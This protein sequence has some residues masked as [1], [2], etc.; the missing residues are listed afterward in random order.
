MDELTWLKNEMSKTAEY[1]QWC[2]RNLWK[3][4][5]LAE[6]SMIF[7]RQNE[8]QDLQQKLRYRVAEL[9]SQ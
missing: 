2:V 5:T 8:L 9:V 3:S 6:F 4:K 1:I 7:K